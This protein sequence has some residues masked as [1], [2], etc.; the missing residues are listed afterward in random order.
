MTPA[1]PTPLHSTE[2]GGIDWRRVATALARYRWL[3]ALVTVLGTGA[4]FLAT[5][6]LDPLYVAQARIWTGTSCAWS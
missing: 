2:D 4:G 1:L 3:V 6:F 5:R